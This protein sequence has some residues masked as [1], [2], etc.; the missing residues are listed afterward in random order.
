MNGA[1]RQRTTL[2]WVL[3]V[4]L[5]VRAATIAPDARARSGL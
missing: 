4:G 3:G 1:R 5:P 2:A